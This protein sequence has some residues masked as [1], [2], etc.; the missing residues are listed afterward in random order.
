M[1]GQAHIL[2]PTTVAGR[3]FAQS[4]AIRC[5]TSTRFLPEEA[6]SLLCPLDGWT[7][8]HWA[9]DDGGTHMAIVARRT[10]IGGLTHAYA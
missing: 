7:A 6:L 4:T 9:V 8:A 1:I 10:E 3:T 5:F 2:Q